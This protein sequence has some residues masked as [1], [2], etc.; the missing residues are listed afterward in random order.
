MAAIAAFVGEFVTPADAA[1]L[2]Q[3]V[4]RAGFTHE[5]RVHVTTHGGTGLAV[6]WGR[7]FTPWAQAAGVQLVLDGRLD[8]R[9]ALR[10]AL[11]DA[12]AQRLDDASDATLVAH[13]Y[14]VWGPACFER[15]SGEF[16]VCVWDEIRRVVVAARDRFGVKPLFHAVVPS[17]LV[18]A[19][20]IAALRGWRG[21]PSHLDNGAIADFLLFGELQDPEATC[22]AGIGR[23]PPGGWTE[24]A[25]GQARRNGVY[26][27]LGP[28]APLRYREPR[29]YVEQFRHVLET[30]VRERVSGSPVSVLMSGGLDSSSVAAIAAGPGCS[31]ASRCLAV[32]AVYDTLFEDSE[33]LF[34]SMT[35]DALGL[36]I[37]HVPVD[38]YELFSRWDEDAGPPE[39]TVEPLSAILRDLLLRAGR[40]AD[41]ALTGDGGDPT[42]L[43]GAVVRHV[44]R[45]PSLTLARGVW[46]TLKRG[47]WPPLGLH[48]GLRRWSGTGRPAAPSWLSSR[49]L[50]C[51]PEARWVAYQ[52][53][54]NPLPAPRGEALSVLRAPGWP[55]NFESADPNTSGLPVE[56]RYPFF[57][58]RVVSFAL[59]LPS[60]P[61]CVNKT[62]LREA[63]AGRLPDAIRLRPKSALAGDPVALRAWP[64]RKLVALV[65]GTPAMAGFI[66]VDA[67]ERAVENENG[68]LTD[69]QPGTLAAAALATWLGTAAGRTAT[70]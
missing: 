12:G 3:M 46:Q 30:A 60:Y 29:Q 44:G 19:S 1:G 2:R 63:M 68:L 34:S 51:D 20:S 65:K 59:S 62:V 6:A 52:Q 56:L 13:A 26:F 10:A 25:A 67:F 15:V 16:A 17:G 48:S 42:L 45:V 58:A 55:Q 61:W 5:A 27:R 57:D 32:T 66:D 18:V 33:R 9:V 36:P 23:V 43:P 69:R 28:V 4:G 70:A 24:C 38:G 14:A 50:A 22:F 54:R 37:D 40:H 64:A 49:L 53:R 35:A 7:G 8:D 47:L 41:V 39:P 11:R 31:P 21:V